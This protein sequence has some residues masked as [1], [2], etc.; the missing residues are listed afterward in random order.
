MGLVSCADETTTPEHEAAQAPAPAPVPVRDAPEARAERPK[1]PD[2][3]GVAGVVAA[4]VASAQ[5]EEPPE[6][7]LD[8]PPTRARPEGLETPTDA[9]FRA[10]DRKD[11]A[12]DRLLHEWDRDHLDAMLAYA[13]D[14]ECFKLANAAA[15]EAYR[16]KS[17]AKTEWYEYKREAVREMNRWQERMFADH[18]GIAATSKF[19]G[20][21]LE[22]HELVIHAQLQAYNDDDRD[23]LDKVEL[24]WAII[25]AKI[26]KY[27]DSL[28]GEPLSDPGRFDIIAS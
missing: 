23:A 10:W 24:H 9:E 5:R 6:P 17:G 28:G 8:V 20:H 13:R 15:G 16:G 12:G 11:P 19:V 26:D 18:P 25:V 14:L 3:G 2:G 1:P 27:T 22:M 7:K 21:L 4:Q